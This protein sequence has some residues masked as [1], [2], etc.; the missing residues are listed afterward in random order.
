MQKNNS[1]FFLGNILWRVEH[2]V[3]IYK[4]Y[5]SAFPLVGIGT[6]S[7]PLSPANVPLPPEPGWGS[8]N[9]DDLRKAQHSAYSVLW[10]EDFLQPCALCSSNFE[11]GVGGLS[12]T[13]RGA[14]RGKWAGRGRGR[15]GT[16]P[17]GMERGVRLCTVHRVPTPHT[18]PHTH[19]P[20]STR[21]K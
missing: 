12:H 13:A 2:K 19:T 20:F 16:G 21:E 15:G 7:T 11:V 4:E 6:L 1:H 14:G 3:H 5:Y 10:R 9:S 17:G 8:P 18:P